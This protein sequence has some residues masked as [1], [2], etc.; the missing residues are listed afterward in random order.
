M[1]PVSTRQILFPLPYVK[2]ADVTLFRVTEVGQICVGSDGKFVAH[3]V[4]PV[5]N[6]RGIMTKRAFNNL[7]RPRTDEM[8]CYGGCFTSDGFTNK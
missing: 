7:L 1:R 6:G 4:G 5:T 2:S 8:S 3:L